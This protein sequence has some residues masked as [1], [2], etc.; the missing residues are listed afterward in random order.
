MSFLPGMNI[1]PPTRI[2]GE[3]SARDKYIHRLPGSRA[4]FLPGMNI[5][6]YIPPIQISRMRL[7]HARVEYLLPTRQQQLSGYDECI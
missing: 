3:L 6:T 7:L 5:R 2:S 1:Y 4:R